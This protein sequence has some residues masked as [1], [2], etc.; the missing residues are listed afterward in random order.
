MLLFGLA[1]SFLWPTTH[2]CVSQR[3]GRLAMLGVMIK[4][5][6]FPGFLPLPK[7]PDP[8][9]W[10]L[11]CATE[12]KK[13][14]MNCFLGS[15]WLQPLVLGPLFDISELYPFCYLGQKC[16]CVT[17]GKTL[18]N[19]DVCPTPASLTAS[20]LRQLMAISI[21]CLDREGSVWVDAS[22]TPERA[23]LS[24]FPGSR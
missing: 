15:E 12:I 16:S 8:G 10:W 2:D 14:Q 7:A 22:G 5:H 3:G 4:E 6:V 18:S 11:L 24:S 23:S 20:H 9:M 21:L 13:F 19:F 17:P 1:S